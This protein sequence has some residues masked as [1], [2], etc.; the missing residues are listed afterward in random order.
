MDPEKPQQIEVP[1]MAQ[2]VAWRSSQPH[3]HQSR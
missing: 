2:T 1:A 3:C